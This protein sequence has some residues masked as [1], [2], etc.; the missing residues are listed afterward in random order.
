MTAAGPARAARP[1]G[2]PVRRSALWFGL[3][4]APA[5]WSA[6]ELVAYGVVAH[7]CYPS[8]QPLL[9]AA[10][11]TV[12]VIDLLVSLGMLLL[13]ALA[14]LASFRSWS[15]TRNEGGPESRAHFMALSGIIL[16]LLFLFSIVMNTILLFIEPACS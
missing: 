5:A 3:F 12:V 13:A 2:A 14:G 9:S 7:G 10:R 15:L 11:P 4:G 16:S 8:W 6:Q 1:H